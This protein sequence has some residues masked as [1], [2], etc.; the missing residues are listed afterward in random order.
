MI[1]R[2][3]VLFQRVRRRKTPE[4]SDAER[5]PFFQLAMHFRVNRVRS[6]PD[7]LLCFVAGDGPESEFVSQFIAHYYCFFFISQKIITIYFVS[8]PNFS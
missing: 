1:N 4:D 6:Q 5:G 2:L 3:V 7:L 8:I